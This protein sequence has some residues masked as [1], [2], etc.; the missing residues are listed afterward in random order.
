ML[1]VENET[2]L[3]PDKRLL[4]SRF[5]RFGIVGGTG[6]VVNIGFYALF[7]DLFRVKLMVASAMA[8][9]LSVISNFILNEYWTFKDR[10]SG[11][12]VALLARGV[13][14]NLSV[15]LGGALQLGTLGTLTHYLHMWDKAALL[16][17]ICLGA[18][19]NYFVCNHLIFRNKATPTPP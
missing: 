6:V 3:R 4:R 15:L 14:F 17:G 18:L 10:K 2:K 13:L 11:K 1:P 8:F 9:E 7:H 19:T 16:I 12:S 5:I